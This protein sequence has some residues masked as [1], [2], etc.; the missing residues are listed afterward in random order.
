MAVMIPTVIMAA[1]DIMAK[2]VFPL[3]CNDLSK[4]VWQASDLTTNSLICS[5][6]NVDRNTNF[7]IICLST[8][9]LNVHRN[10]ILSIC[11]TLKKKYTT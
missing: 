9:N 6:L 11:G 7:Y 4:F 8:E 10:T 5:N 2:T 1:T 3:I